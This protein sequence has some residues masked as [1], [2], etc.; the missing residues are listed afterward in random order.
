MNSLVEVR[1]PA[2]Q[3]EVEGKVLASN[4]DS[5]K[6][7]VKI[8]VDKINR[9]L[10]VDED[11]AGAEDDI[12]FCGESER[13]LKEKH[14]DIQG[15]ITTVDQVLR[16]IMFCHDMFRTARLD[17][18]RLV[19]KQKD[20]KKILILTEA[21]GKLRMHL[22]KCEQ[23]VTPHRIEI[24][25]PNFFD[26][27]KGRRSLKA[28]EEAVQEDLDTAIMSIDRVAADV[29]AKLSWYKE[30]GGKEYPFLF[31]DLQLLLNKPMEDYQLTITS[32]V[33]DHKEKEEKKLEKERLKIRLEEE[34]KARLKVETEQKRKDLAKTPIQEHKIV[35]V[36]APVIQKDGA[37]LR[38]AQDQHTARVKEDLTNARSDCSSFMA[39]Y[40]TIEL[41]S[42]IRTDMLAFLEVTD[43]VEE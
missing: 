4:L 38:S 43:W 20:S 27:M 12:K 5:F 11:F 6:G 16:T 42:K 32:R 31:G 8:L 36:P 23:E 41:T 7:E 10:E 2:L 1:L 9:S 24:R 30:S 3:V 28:C 21:T 34:T 37:E 39:K 18:E 15:Q 22:A 33:R 13:S 25:E 29:R 35:E 40:M 14:S 19:K 26:S 17:L